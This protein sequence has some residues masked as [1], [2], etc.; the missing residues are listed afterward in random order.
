MVKKNGDVFDV[1]LSATSEHDRNGNA[2]RS[3]A[4]LVDVTER[5]RA[6][7]Q[8]EES[9][10][11]LRLALEG[12]REGLWDWNVSTGDLFISPQAAPFWAMG[13]TRFPMI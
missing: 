1:L 9:E 7:R 10:A 13:R 8:A 12:A 11:R 6:L 5:N 4:V 2:V 3:L